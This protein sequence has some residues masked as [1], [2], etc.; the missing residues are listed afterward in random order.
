MDFYSAISLKW[1]ICRSTGTNYLNSESLLV[2]VR[3]LM[4]HAYRGS[5]YLLHSLWSNPIRRPKPTIYCTRGGN[6][7]IIST[8]QLRCDSRW[9][10][11]TVVYIMKCPTHNNILTDLSGRMITGAESEW[12]RRIN[13][14]P[15]RNA[16]SITEGE[17]VL[18]WNHSTETICD[19]CSLR[20]FHSIVA[21]L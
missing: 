7:N 14:S 13:L 15:A 1:Q 9:V 17:T 8:T 10:T 6:L 19:P 2:P 11:R 21:K 18:W 20:C 5:K 4:L 3:T 16:R 12:L